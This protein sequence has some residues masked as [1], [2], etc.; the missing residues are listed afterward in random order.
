MSEGRWRIS[1]T[2]PDWGEDHLTLDAIVAYVDD[3][4]G[5]GPYSRAT[6]HV[7]L[8]VPPTPI[9]VGEELEFLTN[10]HAFHAALAAI[11]EPGG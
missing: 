2:A 6:R 1:V 7:A 11:A 3:E 4:L 10:D 9:L 5:S 8:R